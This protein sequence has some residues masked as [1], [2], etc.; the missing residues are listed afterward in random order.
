MYRFQVVDVQCHLEVRECP[1]R[2]GAF[3]DA[4]IVQLVPEVGVIYVWAFN[5]KGWSFCQYFC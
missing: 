2:G 4:D 1:G 5:R 3:I